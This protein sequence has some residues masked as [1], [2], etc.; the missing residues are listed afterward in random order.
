MTPGGGALH[1][2][3][4]RVS[5]I[6]RLAIPPLTRH[7][8]RTALGVSGL[9]VGVAAVTIM[10]AIGAGAERRVLERVR[11]MGTDLVVVMAPPAPPIA[12][13][14][15][16]VETM[17]TLRVAD[18]FAIADDATHARAVAPGVSRAMTVRRAGLNT[19]ATVIG[20][21]VTGARIRNV[22]VAS[23]R[24]FEEIEDRE[25]RRVALIGPVVA[26]NLFGPIDPIGYEIRLD[27]I[28]FEVIGVLQPRGIDPG[29]TDHDNEVVIPLETAMRRVLNVPFVHAIYAQ[30]RHSSEVE[31]LEGEVRT[32]LDHRHRRRSGIATPFTI[33]N[34]AVALRTE[35]GAARTL[36]RMTLGVAALAVLVGGVG[37]LAIMLI[38]VRERVREIGLRRAIGARRDDIWL[39]FLIESSLLAIGGGVTGAVLGVVGATIASIVGPWDLIIEWAAPALAVVASSVLGLAAG[40]LPAH[41]AA[42]LEPIDALGR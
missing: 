37:V 19:I 40:V 1:V 17:T 36:G 2:R 9:A 20:T 7:P 5:R 32:I 8:L 23:G 6:V 16:Q 4:Q 35:A 11:A 31:A 12:G 30:A 41:R 21:T 38:S 15:R 39:Q 33:R 28:P 10:V 14:Q 24:P 26:R 29:G 22:V 13:R 25:R 18:A 3:R 27:R 42:R 34:Q